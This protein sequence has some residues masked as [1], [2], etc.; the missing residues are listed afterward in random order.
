MIEVP[1]ST[2]ILARLMAERLHAGQVRKDGEDYFNH[3]ERVA[4]NVRRFGN[5]A[6]AVAFLHDVLED[7]DLGVDALQQIFGARLALDVLALTRR[8]ADAY[9]TYIAQIARGSDTALVVKLADVADNLIGTPKESLSN[10]YRRAEVVLLEEAARR[11]LMGEPPP[12][13]SHG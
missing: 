13:P 1:P 3:C 10:R 9:S 4:W 6:R 5:H 12:T 11:G 8:P 7:T 2:A